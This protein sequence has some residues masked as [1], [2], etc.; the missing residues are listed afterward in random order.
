MSSENISIRIAKL[1]KE[2]GLSQ[3]QLGDKLGLSQDTI[4]NM[5]RGRRTTT[6]EKIIEIANFFN[7]SSDYLLG[8][9]DSRERK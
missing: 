6:T 2:S 8:I 4:S 3:S 9:S 5:E 7:V 1:R